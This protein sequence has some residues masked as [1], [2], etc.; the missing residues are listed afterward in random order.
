MRKARRDRQRPVKAE[1][2]EAGPPTPGSRKKRDPALADELIA[3]ISVIIPF[4]G[5]SLPLMVQLS[6]AA[7]EAIEPELQDLPANWP[8]EDQVL[9]WLEPHFRT[10]VAHYW[11]EGRPA[12]IDLFPADKLKEIDRKLYER[13]R[14]VLL[15]A[16]GGDRSG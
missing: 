1:T 11:E 6:E 5:I 4:G 14:A 3:N 9:V 7:R 13:L 2:P 16:L 8:F 12:M 10:A 15:K